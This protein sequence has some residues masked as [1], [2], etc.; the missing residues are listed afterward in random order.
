VGR[1]ATNDVQLPL[2]DVS[3][4]H[5]RFAL[6][7]GSVSVCDLGSTNG[8]FL[9]DREL[10]PREEFL[11]R[12]GDHVHV[13]GVIFKFLYGGNVEA[14][15]HEEVYRTL[16]VDGLTQ[17]NNRRYLLDFL[18][19]EMARCRRHH[20]PLA[21]V[22]LDVDHFKAINDAFGHLAGDQ[23]LRELAGLIARSARREECVARW[24]G[25]E[26]ALVLPETDLAGALHFAERLRGTVEQ[27]EFRADGEAVRVTASIGVASVQPDMQAPEDFLRAADARL[28]EAK[29]GGRNRVA[30]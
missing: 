4:S 9:N 6:R 8:T 11:L 16:I 17:V 28:Y 23:V 5:C 25:E 20:R 30:G 19:R 2:Q 24:G 15:Y 1:D 3:R 12:S 14:L 21:L 18:D 13:G 7:D 22:V 27:R 10:P 29:Q 26:F